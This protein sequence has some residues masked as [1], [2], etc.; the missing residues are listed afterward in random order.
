MHCDHIVGSVGS[1][2]C[3]A[4]MWPR[5][6]SEFEAAVEF[7][8]TT[9]LAVPHPG[10]SERHAFCFKCGARIDPKVFD[11]PI[12]KFNGVPQIYARYAKYNERM[13]NVKLASKRK[14]RAVR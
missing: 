13:K 3:T 2:Y 4:E 5:Y 14:G 7:F 11:Q 10:F 8:N 1:I 9:R 6:V 12:P